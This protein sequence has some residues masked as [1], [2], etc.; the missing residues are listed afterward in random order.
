[1][2]ITR[3]LFPTEAEARAFGQGVE[4]ANDSALSVAGTVEVPGEGW[5]LVCWDDD[6]EEDHAGLTAPEIELG[7]QASGED[8]ERLADSTH[9]GQFGSWESQLPQD[10]EHNAVV[11]GGAPCPDDAKEA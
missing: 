9:A 1:M 11:H 8:I 2:A 5:S 4:Y 6:R 3:H 7:R 10:A